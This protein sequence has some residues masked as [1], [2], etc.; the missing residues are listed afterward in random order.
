MQVG[1]PQPYKDYMLE[2][3]DSYVKKGLLSKKISPCGLLALYDYTEK[4]QFD[5]EWD[6]V[7]LNHRGTVYELETG[8]V[9]ARA[10]PKFFNFSELNPEEQKTKLQS[11]NFSVYE[12][13]DGSL[14]IVYWWKGE[15]RVNTRGSFT[16]DQA[17]KGL[18]MLN[19][20]RTG[21]MN[22]FC[23]Y[24][25][26]IIYPANRIVV[27]YKGQEKLMF[28]SCIE[29]KN[30][31]EHR[32]HPLEN[33]AIKY[34]FNS[35]SEVLAK[36]KTLPFNEE[37]YVVQFEDGSRAKFKGDEYV[38]MHRLISGLS[39]LT[40]WERME[41]GEVSKDFLATIPEEFRPQYEE[42]AQCLESTHLTLK[43]KISERFQYVV[44]DNGLIDTPAEERRKS[45]GLYLKDYPHELND[46]MFPVLLAKYDVIDKM[47]KKAIRPN[48]NKL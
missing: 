48:G 5:K 28:L 33:E 7:T 21:A 40:I 1:G 16:S 47:I 39:P 35:I 46:F 2:L 29:N 18:E 12:K 13:M 6:E 43:S 24:L 36:L 31:K 15:W 27:D 22:I 34:D 14:G 30:G 8:D 41:N 38:E 19:K 4:C 44:R 23:T 32:D 26:E 17:I 9:V 11:K 25:V 45:L 42:I 20:L 37:G 3:L 10:F